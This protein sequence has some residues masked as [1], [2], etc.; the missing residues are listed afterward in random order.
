MTAHGRVKSGGGA[1]ECGREHDDRGRGADDREDPVLHPGQAG[2]PH[3]GLALIR[4]GGLQDVAVE[5]E[6][7]MCQESAEPGGHHVG[8]LLPG[9]FRP[10][11][12]PVDA[13]VGEVIAGERHRQRPGQREQ[14]RPAEIRQC[15]GSLAETGQVGQPGADG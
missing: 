5:P 15:R 12:H 3:L 4:P 14:P 7:A 1:A 2:C 13:L 9:Q 6:T 11:I 10:A 8:H